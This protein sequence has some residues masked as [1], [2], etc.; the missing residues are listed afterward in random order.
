ML[1]LFKQDKGVYKEFV[2]QSTRD[3]LINRT[4]IL[5]TQIN[6]D[7][8]DQLQLYRIDYFSK[9]EKKIVS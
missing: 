1:F 9:V 2:K 3:C 6:S 4:S 5:I 7:F 8:D